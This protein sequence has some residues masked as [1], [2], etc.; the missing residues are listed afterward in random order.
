[1][2]RGT[3]RQANKRPDE[4]AGPSVGRSSGDLLSRLNHLGFD[5]PKVDFLDEGLRE[6]FLGQVL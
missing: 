4:S 5:E 6:Q 2:A 3:L 1:M